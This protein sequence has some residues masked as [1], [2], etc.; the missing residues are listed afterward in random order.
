MISKNLT[1]KNYSKN[2]FSLVSCYYF[3]YRIFEC[4]LWA[5]LGSRLEPGV[6]G[7]LEPE[8]EPLEKKSRSWSRLEK[9]SGAPQPCKKIKSIRK[10]YSSYSILGK[11][12]S[13]YD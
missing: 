7:S 1:S 2:M 12:V 8:P 4:F 11:I 13:F 5:G 6:F 10:L 9:K 3:P